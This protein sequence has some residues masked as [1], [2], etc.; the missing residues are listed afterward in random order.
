[1]E[2]KKLEHALETALGDDRGYAA[3]L[4]TRVNTKVAYHLELRLIHI[5]MKTAFLDGEVALSDAREGRKKGS[6][7]SPETLESLNLDGRSFRPGPPINPVQERLRL[8]L[9]GW[10]QDDPLQTSAAY[11][12]RA[13]MFQKLVVRPLGDVSFAGRESDGFGQRRERAPHCA[14]ARDGDQGAQQHGRGGELDTLAE[15]TSPYLSGK[16]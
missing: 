10:F 11:V 2:D 5:N 1:M 6:E 9:P 3:T 7:V 15:E 16:Q 12:A 13:E 14:A 8:R 4:P